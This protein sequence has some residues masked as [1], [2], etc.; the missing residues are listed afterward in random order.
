MK[1]RSS[2]N[3]KICHA[4]DQDLFFVVYLAS[5]RDLIPLIELFLVLF[6]FFF[7]IQSRIE[8]HITVGPFV[9]PVSLSHTDGLYLLLKSSIGTGRR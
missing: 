4:Y 7:I 6:L 9:A 2:E 1:C 5:A 3:V 8:C